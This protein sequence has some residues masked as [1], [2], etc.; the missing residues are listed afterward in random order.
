MASV[1]RYTPTPMLLPADSA[2]TR[3]FHDMRTHVSSPS[4][5]NDTDYSQY[6]THTIFND[7]FLAADGN[8]ISALGPPLVNLVD[9]LL[10]IRVTANSIDSNDKAALTHR[11]SNH[12]RVTFHTFKLPRS[13][14][15]QDQLEV[16]VSLGSGQQQEF[17]CRRQQLAP[18]KLQYV[19]LQ[20]NNPTP[21]ILDWIR[22]HHELGVERFLIYDNG[23][24]NVDELQ[25]DLGNLPDSVDI[26][27]IDWPY[28]YG[29]TSSYYNQF[30]QATQNNH[31]YQH[32]GACQWTGH[33][34]IDEFMVFKQ[35]DMMS[36]LDKTGG[37]TGQ[38]RFD[39]YWVPNIVSRP[40]EQL[41]T[42]RN[43]YH[44]ER[45]PRGTSRK[46]IVRN[47]RI[48]MA[49][50]HKAVMKFPWMRKNVNPDHQ[51]FFHYKPLATNWKTYVD[52]HEP[53]Q[54]DPSEHVEDL[55][56]IK[57]IESLEV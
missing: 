38:L 7:L 10:P 30:C 35:G 16:T 57:L 28:R 9:E 39:S 33:F 46:Y 44:R 11:L 40:I 12:D 8:S 48:R 42:L 3:K 43:Y 6:E 37:L 22:Y 1:A 26:V 47:D 55:A 5:L 56:V 31:A 2:V 24:D 14:A 41:P 36:M 21:W 29:P 34:D 19:T 49:N 51:V 20:K 50:T 52:R 45:K 13:L 32:F 4:T 15:G 25:R 23:S 53:D 17:L 27:L 18:V 54:L